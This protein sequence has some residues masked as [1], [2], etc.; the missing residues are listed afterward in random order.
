MDN[1]NPRKAYLFILGI[2]IALSSIGQNIQMNTSNIKVINAEHHGLSFVNFY[3]TCTD[4]VCTDNVKN[5]K[6]RVIRFPSAGDADNY[7]MNKD[8]AGYG[9]NFANVAAYLADRYN[10]IQNPLTFTPLVTTY[11]CP[12]AFDQFS[13]PL[14]YNASVPSV[15]TTTAAASSYTSELQTWYCNYRRQ[16]TQIPQSYLTKF[17]QYVKEMEDSL[18]TG[19]RINVIYVANIFSG[20]PADLVKT[21]DQLTKVSLNGIK[22]INVVGIELSNESWGKANND[23]FP[24]LNAGNQFYNYVRGFGPPLYT[25]CLTPKGDFI[26]A[27][28]SNFPN[29]KIGFPTAPLAAATHTDYYGCSM[30]SSSASRFNTW[31]TQLAT[32]LN[33]VIN[34]TVGSTPTTVTSGDAFVIH[35]YFDDK[36][37]GSNQEGMP[38]SSCNNCLLN[39]TGPAQ[40]KNYLRAHTTSSTNFNHPYSY[41]P[42]TED[43]TLRSSFDCQLKETFKFIDSG[44]VDKIMDGYKTQ[45]GISAANN[46]KIWMTEWNIL[47]NNN[48]DT[49]Y[50][51]H[52]TFNHAVLTLG[53]KMAMFR[54]NWEITGSSDMFQ[55]ST[56]F[57]GVSAQ[58]NGCLSKRTGTNS[59]GDGAAQDATSGNVKRMAYWATSL[60]RH[61][62]L[63]SLNWIGNTI[64]NTAAYP[65][66][67]FY[68]FI[69]PG[70][71]YMYVYYINADNTDLNLNLDSIKL[72]G[73]NL[74]STVYH[75]YFSLKNNYSTAG[76]SQSFEHNK[77]YKVGNNWQTLLANEP[78]ATYSQVAVS[79]KN[80]NLK[81]KSIG[82]IKIPLKVVGTGINETDALIK[83]IAFYPNPTNGIVTISALS[84]I[85]ADIKVSNILGYTI[86]SSK[87]NGQTSELDLKEL[88]N[89][90]YLINVS[91]KN[92]SATYKVILLK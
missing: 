19:E 21:L 50:L 89:G 90:M 87:M 12:I 63:D 58:Q 36:Y 24:D 79:A 15:F 45:L 31:N 26:S 13:V 4:N 73:Y 92:A 25:G 80:Y 37:W 22:S 71:K 82:Y 46:K 7:S 32:N 1:I 35:K 67:R 48:D 84:N 74:D 27:I 34:V 11:T 75:E 60:T 64:N 16:K 8:T 85:N 57:N 5:L 39:T 14:N 28:R 68:T 9:I 30:A 3:N 52:N 83:N 70:N 65:N 81:R 51:F 10:S 43:D 41:Y 88:S 44:F 56:F 33:T 38:G 20:T 66:T 23:I 18:Q 59:I 86:M 53:W 62:S 69:N 40:Y 78:A 54:S 17:I 76:Y 29:I 72:T 47:E 2:I 91:S 6:P 55:Y 49:T 42:N 77:F 61:I